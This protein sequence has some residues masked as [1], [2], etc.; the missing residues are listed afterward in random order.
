MARFCWWP[1]LATTDY[2]WYSKRSLFGLARH[3]EL[4]LART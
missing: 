3:A 1:I 4:P 2:R